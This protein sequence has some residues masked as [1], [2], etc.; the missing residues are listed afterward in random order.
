MTGKQF[1]EALDHLDPLLIEKY[2]TLKDSYLEKKQPAVCLKKKRQSLWIKW[3]TVA[4][5]ICL[6][7][8]IAIP[9]FQPKGGPSKNDPFRPLNVIEYNGAYYECIDIANTEILDKYNLPHEITP[10]MIG[11]S[12]GTGWDYNGKQ[13]EQI[14]YQYVPYANIGVVSSQL[15]EQRS[16]RAVFIAEENNI[17]SFA[18]FSIFRIALRN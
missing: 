5:S 9:I 6:I 4:V 14:L 17:Y 1:H 13:T 3:S 8:G 10:D 18:L 11:I 7:I 12:L 15:N 16:Q 2:Y